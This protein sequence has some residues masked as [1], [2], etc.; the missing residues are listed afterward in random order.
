M[1]TR[2]IM[3]KNVDMPDKTYFEGRVYDSRFRSDIP[4]AA[5][6]VQHYIA[7]ETLNFFIAQRWAHEQT[8]DEWAADK[9]AFK[10]FF[11]MTDKIRKVGT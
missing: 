10:S 7:Q 1:I 8:W 11:D 3:D 4:P 6:G 2:I 5:D 9:P